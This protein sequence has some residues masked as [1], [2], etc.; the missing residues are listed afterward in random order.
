MPQN[1]NKEHLQQKTKIYSINA[2]SVN[3]FVLRKWPQ[4]F[5]GRKEFMRLRP[6]GRLLDGTNRR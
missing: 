2:A 6:R 4:I 3:L 1:F 5:R